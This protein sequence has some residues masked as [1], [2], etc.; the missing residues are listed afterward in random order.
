MSIEQLYSD[1]PP[2]KLRN[3]DEEFKP[4]KTTP[5]WLWVANQFFYGMLENRF[6]ALRYKGEEKFFNRD[7]SIPT[8]A[9]APHTNWWR[10]NSRL[11]YL[12]KNF[13][14]RNSING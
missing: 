8:I 9:F 6:F 10:W 3:Q 5:F 12:Q 7:E 4:A 11:Q 14:Q 13:Q 2:T 1:I